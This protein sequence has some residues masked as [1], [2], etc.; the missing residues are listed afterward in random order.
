MEVLSSPADST[1]L[2]SQGKFAVLQ[3]WGKIE[4]CFEV[5]QS[6]VAGF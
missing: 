6:R 2:N 3:L 4:L 1:E 5:Q